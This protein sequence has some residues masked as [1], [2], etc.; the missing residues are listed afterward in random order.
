MPL[1]DLVLEPAVGPEDDTATGE[2]GKYAVVLYNDD[3]TPMNFVVEV[4]MAIFGHSYADAVWIMLTVHKAGRGVA[5]V[6]SHEIAEQKV[7]ETTD[8]ANAQEHPLLAVMERA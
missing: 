3:F 4:L 7:I 1:H 8:R 5:G 2:P 6:Y